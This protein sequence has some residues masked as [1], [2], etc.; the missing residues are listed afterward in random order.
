MKE[1]KIDGIIKA[2]GDG[3]TVFLSDVPAK[4]ENIYDKL[5]KIYPSLLVLLCTVIVCLFFYFAAR[6][7][8]VIQFNNPPIEIPKPILSEVPYYVEPVKKTLKFAKLMSRND[9]K[10]M[11][12]FP[13]IKTPYE[14]RLTLPDNL[15][16]DINK[17]TAQKNKDNMVITF[18]ELCTKEPQFYLEIYIDYNE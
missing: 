7:S 17:I 14:Y 13:E 9:M 16:T 6:P 8:Q 2:V 18:G 5:K 10:I 1:R 4:Q 11:V 12:E 3:K 15:K